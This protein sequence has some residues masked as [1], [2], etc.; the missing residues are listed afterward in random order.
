M[1][2]FSKF[3][4]FLERDI[5]ILLSY[6]F[7]LFIQLISSFF[8]L[9]MIF[10]IFSREADFDKSG[11]L[12]IFVGIAL[13]DFMMSSL[14]VFSKEVRNAQTTGTFEA[15]ILTKTSPALLIFSSYALTLFRA[16]IRISIYF[17]ICKLF[18][19][20]HLDLSKIPLF[21]VAAM[22]CSLPFIGLGMMSASFII[23]FK[24]GNIINLLI[25]LFSIFSS[26]I[27][28]P[29]SILS[30]YAAE[31][32]SYSPLNIG[33]E[34]CTQIVNNNFQFDSISPLLLQISYMSIALI[35]LGILLVYYGISVSKR[36]GSLNQY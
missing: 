26:G 23:V 15:L 6:K 8:I 21:L 17:I 16:C 9:L 19:D 33:L 18:F 34:V 2:S 14:T 30:D 24:V 10:L 12:N 31:I 7:N 27:F 3:I 29:T 35:P 36:N 32:S 11:F 25:S 13:I 5:K 20:I 22:F 4:A 28:F 1:N